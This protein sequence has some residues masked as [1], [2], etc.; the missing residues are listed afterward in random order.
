MITVTQNFTKKVKEI[1]EQEKKGPEFGIRVG[2]SSNG[3]GMM[4]VLDFDTQ[5][6]DDFVLDQDGV[7]VL[8]DPK[9]M[10]YL[11]GSEF[12]YVQ[13]NFKEGFA[14]K[15]PNAKQGCGC[16]SGGCGCG[17]GGCGCGGH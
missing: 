11:K 10:E 3:H 7:K 17:Q 14:I 1:M 2:V 6:Q 4:Y 8:V 13:T 16:G 9:S 12:D 5:K 15:N